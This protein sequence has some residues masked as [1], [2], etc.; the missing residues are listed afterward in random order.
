MRGSKIDAVGCVLHLV[1]GV[2]ASVRRWSRQGE[3]TRSCL[4]FYRVLVYSVLLNNC[5][6]NW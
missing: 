3:K 1:T 6:A 4:R 2:C 5:K